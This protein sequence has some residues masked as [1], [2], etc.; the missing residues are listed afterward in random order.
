MPQQQ[1]DALV[2]NLEQT[3]RLQAL[4]QQ[5]EKMRRFVEYNRKRIMQGQQRQ[6]HL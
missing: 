2:F 5:Q 4:Q 1:V 3:V 6:R